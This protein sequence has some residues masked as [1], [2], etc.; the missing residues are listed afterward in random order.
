M[1]QIFGIL[2]SFIFSLSVNAQNEEVSGYIQQMY[3]TWDSIYS[4]YST[5]YPEG[6]SSI[7]IGLI[8][9]TPNLL[10][11]STSPKQSIEALKQAILLE[12]AKVADGDIGLGFRGD[13]VYNLDPGFGFEDNLFYDQKF[14]VSVEMDILKSGYF[15]NH[16]RAKIKY[17]ELEVRKKLSSEETKKE[18]RYLKWHNIIYQFNRNKIEV[19]RSREKLAANRVSVA[20]KLNHLKYVSQED[21]IKHISSHAEIQ[22]MLNIYQDY[23]DQLASELHVSNSTPV[24]YPAIDIDYSYSYKLLTNEEPDSIAELL[25]ENLKLADKTINDFKLKPFIAFNFYDLVGYNPDFRTF[26]SVGV[27]VAAPLNFNTKNRSNLREA[28]ANLIAI[29]T[30]TKPEVQ[31]DVLTQFYEFR[32]KLKQYTTLFHKRE[33]YSELIRQ[34]RVK[35]DVAPLTFNPIKAL[36]LMDQ[37]MQVDIEMIDTKQQMYLKALNIYTDLPYSEAENLIK[38]I[39]LKQDQ[40]SANKH[41]NSIYVWSSTIMKNSPSVLAHYIDLN[42]FS[43]ATISLNNKTEAREK[44]MKL[45]DFLIDEDKEIEFM[46][47]NNKLIH[48]GF[49]EYMQKLET[50]VDWSKISAIH[51]DVEPH[52]QDDWHEK[53]PEYLK[54]YHA[55]L[56]EANKFCEKNGLKLGVSIPTHYPEED[57]FKIF[58]AV[59]RV[60]FMCYENVKTDFI[61]RK[62]MKYPTEKKYIALRTNDFKNRLEMEQKFIELNQKTKTAGYVVHDLGSML[63]FDTNSINKQ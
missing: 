34:E 45:V 35:H 56:V 22:S 39:N 42:P 49:Q 63:E 41:K 9:N 58:E 1:K 43:R 13:Y 60:Y 20:T 14:R 48:G 37:L 12:E 59:D 27:T 54:K 50:G 18:E 47:G 2:A 10:Q 51:L 15:E 40:N 32:Y 4:I 5:S 25:I 11:N 57:I 23:N 31:E 52:T 8:K 33:T 16:D 62:T 24:I 3:N 46:I 36:R 19:L 21:L 44:T 29:P 55:L 30:S 26:F 61:V 7:A 28:Q 38:P 17:N 6:D 53:K